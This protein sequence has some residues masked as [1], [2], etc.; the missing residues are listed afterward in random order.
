MKQTSTTQNKQWIT[1]QTSDD[2]AY[3]VRDEI[4]L[5]ANDAIKDHGEFRIV[6]AGGS[7]PEQVYDLLAKEDCDWGHWSI[8]LGDERCLPID[9][10]ERN[11][12]MIQRI[13]LNKTSIPENN[14]HFIPAELGPVEAARLYSEATKHSLPFDLVMLG[15]GEDGHTASLFP[16]HIH[17]DLE[18]LSHAVYDSPKLP[19][20]RVSLSASCLSNNQKL[21]IMTTGEGKKKAIKQW[22]EGAALPVSTIT[23]QGEVK[24]FLD[25]AAAPT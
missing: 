11:S 1:L 7:T 23:S 21:L 18:E 25:Q 10:P 16:G 5:A 4:L 19:L 13:L 6:L 12:Q 8:Y 17:N 22:L 15:M 24:I 20:E 3:A 9:D 14:I 2:V